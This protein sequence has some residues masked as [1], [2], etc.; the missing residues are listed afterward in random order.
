MVASARAN[1]L[2]SPIFAMTFVQDFGAQ[3]KAGTC[4]HLSPKET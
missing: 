2:H 3:V 4:L 1:G